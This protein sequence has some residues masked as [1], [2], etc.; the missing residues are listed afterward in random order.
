MNVE[1]RLI[2]FVDR[3]HSPQACKNLFYEPVDGSTHLTPPD[4]VHEFLLENWTGIGAYIREASPQDRERFIWS[5]SAYC[6]RALIQSL[7]KANQYLEADKNLLITTT[8][9]YQTLIRRIAS[10]C[11]AGKPEYE[12]VERALRENQARLKD[13]LGQYEELQTF[14]KEQPYVQAIP[15]SEYSAP[16]QLR[17]L[18][19]ESAELKEPILDIGCGRKANLVR[20]LRGIGLEAY[21]LDR[22]LDPRDYLVRNNWLEQEY[23]PDSWGTVISHLAFSNHFV[24]NHLRRKGNY[25]KYAEKYMEILRSLKLGGSFIYVPDMPFIECH[26]PPEKFQVTGEAAEVSSSGYPI[27]VSRITRLI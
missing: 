14:P 6:S 17:V 24:R 10:I 20:Y 21:G 12:L 1:Q 18:Q 11:A 5:L 15:C 7:I 3:I 13:V 26:L 25:F 23:V 4:T 16:M 2:E 8:R 19:V 9:L 27:R 22:S